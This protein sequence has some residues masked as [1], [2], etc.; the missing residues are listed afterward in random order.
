MS[1]SWRVQYR[2]KEEV[3]RVRAEQDPISNLRARLVENDIA[4]EDTL[5]AIDREIKDAVTEAA[6]FAEQSPEPDPS[7]LYT[8]VLATA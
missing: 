6:E 1:S 8:D 2:S 5:K 3:A 7:E 4:D